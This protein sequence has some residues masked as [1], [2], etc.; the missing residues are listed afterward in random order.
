MNTALKKQ[1]EELEDM[2]WKSI[3]EQIIDDDIS[4][5]QIQRV[6]EF[7]LV[8]RQEKPSLLDFLKDAPI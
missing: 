3:N 6:A 2:L 8:L 5:E 1:F 7:I 4:W